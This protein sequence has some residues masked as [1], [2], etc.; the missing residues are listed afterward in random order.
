VPHLDAATQPELDGVVAQVRDEALEPR[1][2]GELERDVAAVAEGRGEALCARVEALAARR[3]ERRGRRLRS[4]A[5]PGAAPGRE[6]AGARG[7]KSS[8]RSV[9]ARP[10]QDEKASATALASKPEWTMQSRQ[11]GFPLACP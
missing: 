2:V 1:A 5:A 4:R 10:R 9:A 11:A 3:G 6:A 7:P 8:A